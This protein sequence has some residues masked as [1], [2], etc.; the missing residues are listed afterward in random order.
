MR[1]FQSEWW[2]VSLP[3]GWTGQ[4]N[5]ECATFQAD[6]SRG[7]FQISA[8]EKSHGSVT[9]EDLLEFASNDLAE[10]AM[11]SPVAYA[12]FSGFSLRKVRDDVLWIKWWLRCETLMVFATYN[13]SADIGEADLP[14]VNY[15]LGSLKAKDK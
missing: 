5:P 9:D 13:E 15:I 3:K 4:H 14:A 1:A 12:L 2:S 8:V 7:A 10:R 6:G 11:L